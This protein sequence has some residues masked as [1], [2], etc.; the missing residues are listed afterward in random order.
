MLLCGMR[1]FADGEVEGGG[2]GMSSRT[3]MRDLGEG[4]DGGMADGRGNIV[5]VEG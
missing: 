5:K 4:G 3:V 2:F 1:F